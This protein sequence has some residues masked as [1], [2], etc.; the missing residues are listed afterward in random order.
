LDCCTYDN[1]SDIYLILKSYAKYTIDRDIAD[2]ADKNRKTS[3][4]HTGHM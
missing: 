3:K 1:N 2:N 4:K